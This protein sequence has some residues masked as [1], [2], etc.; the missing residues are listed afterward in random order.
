MRIGKKHVER[1]PA[2]KTLA[3]LLNVSIQW[4][5]IGRCRGDGPPFIRLSKRCV[6]Y[7]L[8]DVQAWLEARKYSH[9][10]QADMAEAQGDKP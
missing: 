3:K 2:S 1:R 6:R 5:E 9:T 4:V 10:A 7:R 8:P